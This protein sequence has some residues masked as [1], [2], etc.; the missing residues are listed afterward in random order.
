M[1]WTAAA[2]NATVFTKPSQC[3]AEPLVY[4]YPDLYPSTL[5]ASSPPFFFFKI[6]F[7]R[8]SN[9]TQVDDT[10][11]PPV[12]SQFFVVMEGKSGTLLFFLALLFSAHPIAL[13]IVPYSSLL[14]TLYI[15]CFS[16][17]HGILV[18]L[19]FSVT[20]GKSGDSRSCHR[21]YRPYLQVFSPPFVLFLFI[22]FYSF[23]L[24]IYFVSLFC[25]FIF[26]Y[27]LY[28]S[29]QPHE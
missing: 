3:L 1:D 24:F 26:I 2:P 17:S 19:R 12:A 20:H 4:P 13:H 8:F 9:F 5:Y 25:S 16:R 7:Y 18:V 14:L 28:V 11:L 29:S 21:C 15:R 10:A 22:Y 23:I 27:V 6:I